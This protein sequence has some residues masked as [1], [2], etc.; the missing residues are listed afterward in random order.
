M[1]QRLKSLELQGYKTFATK[2][3][4]VFSSSVTAIVGPN[5]SGKSNIADAIRWVLGEQSFTL[6]RGRKTEDMIFSGSELRA[7]AGMA[8]ATMVFDNTDQ[9]LPVE[10]SEVAIT[11]RAYRDG[12]NEYLI[13][14]QRVR[15]KDVNEL[16]SR[17]GLSERTYTVIGQGLVDVALAL[18]AEDRRQLFEEA[19][20]IG[21][22]RDRREEALR[23]LDST[24]R[25]IERVYDLL[26]EIE[27][28][29]NSLEK[30]VKRLEE[31]EQI[32]SLLKAL[33][34][35]W[36][37]YHW[38]REQKELVL[39]RDYVK[40]REQSLEEI[41]KKI[42]IKQEELSITRSQILASREQLAQWQQQYNQLTEIHYHN[43]R[44][45]A[46]LQERRESL[47]SNQMLLEAER[48]RYLEEEGYLR[49][50]V[51]EAEL[52]Q[53]A[54]E[55]EYE[56]ISTK[57]LSTRSE[58][59]RYQREYQS[60]K[61]VLDELT[62][63][64]N[65]RLRQK[66]EAEAR[67]N[68]LSGRL[69]QRQSLLEERQTEL[70]KL[71]VV[72][73]AK[74]KELALAEE[75]YRQ[76]YSH[77]AQIQMEL[78]RIQEEEH[79]RQELQ[80][81]KM[82]L[83]AKLEAERMKLTTQLAVLDQADQ[84]FTDY[85]QAVQFLFQKVNHPA[86]RGVLSS[87]LHIPLEYEVAVAA[88]LGELADT[89]IVND[90]SAAD[91]IANL[92]GGEKLR[93]VLLPLDGK[94]TS[95]EEDVLS[96]HRVIGWLKDLVGVKAEYKQ[97]LEKIF[98]RV[99]L[100]EN[101]ETARSLQ[102][103]LPNPPI[104]VTLN[105]EIYY[106]QG[107]LITA[108]KIEAGKLRR[109]REKEELKIEIGKLDSQLTEID[110]EI[111][112]NEKRILQAQETRKDID[113]KQRSVKDELNALERQQSE[114]GK[115][116]DEGRVRHEILK[117][118]IQE[119]ETENQALRAEIQDEKQ[120]MNTLSQQIPILQTKIHEQTQKL[121]E[122]SIDQIRRQ[123]EQ[124]EAYLKAA[125]RS[126]FA[127]QEKTQERYRQL[128]L[129]QQNIRRLEKRQQET[130]E[131][132][133]E[134]ESA[135]TELENKEKDGIQEQAT[136]LAKIEPTKKEL[137]RVE[138]H[139]ETLNNEIQEYQRMMMQQE[140]AFAQL[141]I[142]LTRQQERFDTLRRKIEED[143]G[144]VAF[145]YEDV[146]SG[147]RPLPIEGMVE[148]LPVI[149]QIQPE[150]EEN[151]KRYRHQL[152]RLGPVSP[153]AKAEYEQVKQRYQFMQEQI[154]DLLRAEADILEIL[155]QLDMTIKQD[156]L[157]TYEA[158]AEEFKTIF[159]RLFKGGSARL[160][161]TEAEDLTNAGIEIE[162]RLPGKRTQGLSLLSG[163]ERSLTAVAL[164]F[165]L[166]KVSPTPF[167]VLDEVDAMLDE[168]NIGR[169]Q[170]VLREL[171]QNTQFIIVTHNRN[172]VQ[173]ADIIY[174]V[175]M[176]RDSTSQ[177]VSLKLDELDRVIGSG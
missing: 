155:R 36:Y 12:Q 96:D 3:L 33:L 157:K 7:R 113:L 112:E 4:F 160:F 109:P 126:M 163:G 81:E 46:V 172:T 156:F 32:R 140:Q 165:A 166:L 67:H 173:V 51:L 93:G 14:G 121:A 79:K 169:F 50:K 125:E 84:S 154:A 55:S 110:A 133:A 56:E 102:Q 49:D 1:A 63:E 135:I 171:S 30:Q 85:N 52:E 24:K 151:I 8:H 148:T 170:E 143:F 139:F 72:V 34:L 74:K 137:E 77:F 91:A 134:I 164:I 144:L 97:I 146:V 120:K 66:A 90:F 111:K 29:L 99:L 149:E 152:R 98:F 86:V 122:V 43:T 76:V 124:W 147:P 142:S 82:D 64:L 25:N 13:N 175:T 153:E 11:R 107:Y 117:K 89:I 20:G 108:G 123:V 10:F 136:L 158:V 87:M 80:R 35:D 19:A 9:W 17:S 119:L 47:R 138:S 95:V 38:H 61:R 21:L 159:G 53:K 22:Y 174:G 71:E 41:R 162:A 37:G 94:S 88:Y 176:G 161:L 128:E 92:L 116:I 58:Y 23:R 6:L 106:P 150:L 39:Q 177:V 130:L 59:E 44:Q 62:D 104:I 57:V 145:E 73:T 75:K 16:L 15:L 101:S 2:T 127:A 141:R 70:A 65:F 78:E 114:L 5:G 103:S 167:C 100:V 45:L 68:E 115:E 60:K 131:Q 129:T 69:K 132:L 48:S 54:V 118:L 83:L 168:A 26:S 27:P 18:K 28:R 42:A 105:G 31:Y 40:K